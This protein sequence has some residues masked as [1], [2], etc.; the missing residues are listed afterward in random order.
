MAK[1]IK[2]LNRLGGQQVV[3]PFPVTVPVFAGAI[4]SIKTGMLV[5]MDAVNPGYWLAA[6][7]ATD[8]D[9]AINVG[10]ATSDS[11][12]TV[13]ANGTVTIDTS[14]EMLVSIKANTPA[15]LSVAN[16]GIAYVL[17]VSGS[18]Y[19]LDETAAT[20]GIFNIVDYDNTTDG[21]CI[22]VLKG[23]WRG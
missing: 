17:K 4:S 2:V 9:T 13:T 3:S 16:R 22:C 20:K 21:N 19:M 23:H 12:E 7:D 6:P 1:S 18:D 8:T 5:I 10:V 11:T 15:S 14:D